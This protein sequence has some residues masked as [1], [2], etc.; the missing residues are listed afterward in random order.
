M[1]PCRYENPIMVQ[2]IALIVDDDADFRSALA[3]ILQSEDCHVVEAA[4][5]EEAITIL[6]SVTPDVIL[7]DLIMPVMS[8]WSLFDVIARREELRDVPVVFMSGAPQAAPEG[9]SLV[10]KKPFDLPT[11]L[12]LLRAVGHASPES[13]IRLK[14]VARGG[15][16]RGRKQN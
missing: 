7:V 14:A 6:D 2:P 1:H 5:G 4:N 8:G 16:L 13:A 9:G 12:G 3:E 15:A 10:L 11:L